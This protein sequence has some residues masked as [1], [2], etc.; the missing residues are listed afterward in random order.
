MGRVAAV[1]LDAVEAHPMAAVAARAD[2]AG[3]PKAIMGSL[4][5]VYEVLRA[6]DYGPRGCNTVYY[7]P[8]PNG[9]S[10]FDI[11]SGVR[12][13][14]PFPGPIG[15]VVAA[16]TPAGEAAH[17]IYFG[18][19]SRMHPAHLAAQGAAREAGR[20]LTGDSWEVYGD[21]SNNPD[22]LRTDI[23]YLLKAK[24]DG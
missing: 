4:D 21:W 1:T 22:E 17:A 23:Y 24:A 10:V 11:L 16:E 15:E 5:K 19:Y 2:F 14:R 8:M 18:D 3:L 9:G 20:Q 7:A 12:L 6:G 13:T